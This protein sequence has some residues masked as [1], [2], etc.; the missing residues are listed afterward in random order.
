MEVGS[1]AVPGEVGR[2]S[3]H[4]FG[5]LF[6]PEDREDE[7]VLADLRETAPVTQRSTDPVVDPMPPPLF[8]TSGRNHLESGS[9]FSSGSARAALPS[10]R[11]PPRTVS[12]DDVRAHPMQRRFT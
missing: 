11:A 8:A 4:R 6:T 12:H 1:G 5:G 2:G 9:S 7:V 10:P 3:V